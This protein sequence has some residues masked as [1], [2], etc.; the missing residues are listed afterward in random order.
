[1]IPRFA[2]VTFLSLV[3]SGVVAGE[4]PN[5]I[6]I[7]CDDL[8]YADVG[9][10]GSQ[11]I[12]TPGIDR[13][14]NEG[15]RFTDA[16]VT[17]CVCGPSRAGFMTG[18]Y[19]GRFGFCRNPLYKPDDPNTGLAKEEQTL[20][21]ALQKAGYHTGIIGKWHL[22]A[23]I[24]HHPLNRGFDEFFGHL[25]GGHKYFQADY[26]KKDSASAK[27]EWES[28]HTW[29][30]RNHDPVEISKY[31]TD[32]FSDEAVDFVKR[33]HEKPFFLFLSYN[34]PHG[35]L[36]ASE[37]YLARFPDISNKDRQTYAAMVSAVDDG[38][39][40]LLSTLDDLGIANNTIV[41]FLS[42]NGGAT[43]NASD[44]TPLRGHKS[45]VW[46]GGF[47]V[48]MAVRWPAKF[49]AGGVYKH[50]VS[51]LDIFATIAAE[52]GAPENPGRPL[53]GVNLVPYITGADEGRPHRSI[54]LR[55][56][57]HGQYAIRHLDHKLVG[58]ETDAAPQLFALPNDIGEGNDLA[59]TEPETVEMLKRFYNE[60]ES[61]LIDPA[62][63]G[64]R[65]R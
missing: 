4:K 11:Q 16:Y 50:P 42:D 57:D 33:N 24:S 10:N 29:I 2:L 1:M 25:G 59:P 23:H 41:F 13:I 18:R 28:Y 20:G 60:W 27:N 3:G 14:A 53:D 46:E 22:G 48:P 64:K 56:F 26:Q 35:P 5:L 36:Q 45:N 15:V 17:Y 43:S 9:F 7:M 51:S 37:E 31:L 32:A 54:Y 65:Q 19:Q 21:E 44:N 40:D 61:E 38:V 47:R 58:P 30:M 49:D 55:K 62:F 63:K 12:P 34:A 52:S 6:V 39:V 8:G